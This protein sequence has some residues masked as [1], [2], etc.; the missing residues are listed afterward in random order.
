MASEN[1]VH[2]PAYI[3]SAEYLL[4]GLIRASPFPFADAHERVNQ[5]NAEI[6]PVLYPIVPFKDTVGHNRWVGAWMIATGMCWCLPNTRA[7]T[8][9]LA[10]SLFW[11]SAGAW[12]QWKVGMPYWL[13]VV[14]FSLSW[15]AWYAESHYEQSQSILEQ[16]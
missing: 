12:S 16:Y 15:I 8:A 2:L 3:L 7:R 13:P 6:A 4:G 1:F 14:N 10:L 11:T 9:T 5:K